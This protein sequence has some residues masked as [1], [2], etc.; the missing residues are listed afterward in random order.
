MH[1]QHQSDMLDEM[2]LT[3]AGIHRAALKASPIYFLCRCAVPPA[4]LAWA[5]CVSYRL[6][7]RRRWHEDSSCTVQ[8]AQHARVPSSIQY[9]YMSPRHKLRACHMQQD[10][11][12]CLFVNYVRVKLIVFRP[13]AE[14]VELLSHN[15]LFRRCVVTALL[16]IVKPSPF[17]VPQELHPLVMSGI[18]VFIVPCALHS[19]SN[20]EWCS[21]SRS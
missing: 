21:P 10:V 15:R 14:P 16:N 18:L 19:Q 9:A 1:R 11:L 12:T 4:S 17:C 6:P 13:S 8:L 5:T 3:C 2:T 20:P 7:V